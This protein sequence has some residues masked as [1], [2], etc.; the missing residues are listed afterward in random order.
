MNK[1]YLILNVVEG[2]VGN[3]KQRGAWE[4]ALN[5]AVK[6]AAEQCDTPEDEI[7]AELEE[8]ANFVTPDGDIEVMI[9]QTDDD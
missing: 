5:V 6:L 8:D 3:I 7:R 1:P 4:E 2:K 9:A